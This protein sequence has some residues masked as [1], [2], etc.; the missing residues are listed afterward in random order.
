MKL[1]AKV[2]IRIKESI[3]TLRLEVLSSDSLPNS[4]GYLERAGDCRN[5]AF[6]SRDPQ[7]LTTDD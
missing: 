4:T 5:R 6:D 7:L 1:K 2:R 3:N